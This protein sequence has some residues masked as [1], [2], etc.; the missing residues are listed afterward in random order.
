MAL[1][2]LTKNDGLLVS[3][4]AITGPNNTTAYST[5]LL[6]LKPDTNKTTNKVLIAIKA[7][8]AF[9]TNGTM[10]IYGSWSPTNQESLGE[11][12][13]LVDNAL[14]GNIST[15]WQTYVLDLNAFPAPY[16][17]VAVHSTGDNSGKTFSIRVMVF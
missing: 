6:D 13:Q 7:S 10:D 5:Q 3:E 4:D 2:K 1:T 11:K 16:Y 9:T 17:Y 15:A 14:S 8:G 12:F